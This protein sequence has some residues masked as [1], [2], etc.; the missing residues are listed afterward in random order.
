MRWIA[1]LLVWF[2]GVGPAWG[3]G[4]ES[5]SDRLAS[6][7]NWQ[8]KP[9]T[10]PAKGDLAYPEWMGGTWL[11]RTTQTD[12]VA[13]L[14]P[15]IV[16][17]GFESNRRFLNQPIEFEVRFV[18]GMEQV[19]SDRAF[20]GLSIAKAYLGDQALSVKVDPKSP[21]RQLTVLKD[22]RLLESTISDRAV[23]RPDAAHFLTSE[24]FQ[25]V[26]RSPTGAPFL[27]QVETT[28][29][30]E[31]RAGTP[32]I[33]AD[34]VTAIYLATSDPKYFQAGGRPV[35]IYRYRLEFLPE[36]AS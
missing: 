15:E 29:S 16:T 31:H 1:A 25:Q 11:L 23:E 30:Y 8:G 6:Y 17:P 36:Q 13:P 5:L 19:V 26:F 27:N 20:N 18:P 10:V 7:P 9:T 28:T 12:Q 32:E 2:L 3:M 33:V 14:A 34:Q 21:N 24:V 4:G 35:A 22:D